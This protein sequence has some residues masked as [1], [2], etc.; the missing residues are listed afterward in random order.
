[1]KP[2]TARAVL[3][4]GRTGAVALEPLSAEDPA[5]IGGYRLHSR[6]GAGGMGRVYLAVTPGGRPVALKVVRPEFG[7]DPE[8]RRRFQ[9]EVQASRQV[10]GLYTAEVLDADPDAA[11]PW[12]AAAYVPGPSLQQAVASHGPLPQQTVLLL[13]AGV[14]EALQAIHAAG[15]VHRD[16][17]PSNV[18]LAPDGP[19]VIDFG[20]ARAIAGT[21]VT[22]TGMM[23]GSPQYMAPEQIADRPLSPAIDVFALGA[24]A[25]YAVSGRSPFGEGSDPAVL[26]RIMHEPPSLD[27][28]PEPLRALIGR[29]LAKEPAGRPEPGQIIRTCRSASAGHALQIAGS[30]LPAA[31]AADFGDRTAPA[32]PAGPGQA[33][34]Q[35]AGYQPAEY[36]QAGFGPFGYGQSGS[37]QPGAMPAGAVPAGARQRGAMPPGAMP[38][39]RQFGNRTRAGTGPTARPG[40]SPD[41]VRRGSAGK[42][43]LVAVAAVV[44]VVAVVG[45]LVALRNPANQRPAAGAAGGSRGR[46]SAPAAGATASPA[47]AGR[48]SAAAGQ[49]GQA[50][51]QASCVVGSWAGQTEKVINRIGGEPVSFTGRGADQVLRADGAGRTN[52]GLKTVFTASL[53][54]HH[55]DYIVRGWAAFTWTTQHGQLLIGGVVPHGGWTLRE[56]G[57]YDNSGTLALNEA[58]ERYACT[59]RMLRV[60]TAS[61]SVVL[62]RR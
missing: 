18:L 52:Y 4:T 53:A 12:L 28:C 35:Q 49:A 39:G 26:Y 25:A 61:G 45:G 56:D 13:I 15:L 9:R 16:L 31:V 48:G 37:A 57:R 24:L 30:W 7:D 42:A 5:E 22:R 34:F 19:R 20:I 36:R 11:Q 59:G 6:L 58:P 8:F 21:S 3:V 43:A 14:A 10:H 1:V 17:K 41:D 33:G 51:A 62:R 32:A 38:P 50:A 60:F 23:V 27:D 46:G 2:D 54:G 55:W 47:A 29:C 40:G 44:L